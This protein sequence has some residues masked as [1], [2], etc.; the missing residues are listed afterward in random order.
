MIKFVKKW[1]APIPKKM[2]PRVFYM[3]LLIITSAFVE[4]FSIGS[5]FP[6]LIFL[7]GETPE[8]KYFSLL[9]FE[10]IADYLGFVKLISLFII[11]YFLKSIYLIYFNYYKCNLIR[12]LEVHLTNSLFEKY[13][14]LDF[15]TFRKIPSGEIIRNLTKEIS[16]YCSGFASFIY[17]F[18]EAFILIIL[19]GLLLFVDIKATL[20]VLL[21]LSLFGLLLLKV[22]F[23]KLSNLGATRAKAEKNKVQN[24]LGFINLFP[25]TKLYKALPNIKPFFA[26]FTYSASKSQALFNF[27]GQFPRIF[28]ELAAFSVLGILLI[29]SFF[30][31]Y[32]D[33][34]MLILISIFGVVGLRV[35]PSVS[36]LV[37]TAQVV[38][39]NSVSKE[40]IDQIFINIENNAKLERKKKPAFNFKIS[41]DNNLYLEIKNLTYSFVR[42]TKPLFENLSFKA[43][44]GCP[45]CVS[46][47]SGKGKSTLLEVI[48]GLREPNSGDIILYTKKKNAESDFNIGYVGQK[49]FLFPSTIRDNLL[50]GNKNN[51]EDDDIWHSLKICGMYTFVKKIGLSFEVSEDG[52]TFSG[53][54]IQR[55]G[56]ARALLKKPDLLILDEATTGLD[57]KI[58]SDV[59]KKLHKHLS[60]SII[61]HASHS[62]IVK[63]NCKQEFIIK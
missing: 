18:S 23:S 38:R 43:I 63:E 15:S 37:N 35:L 21:V 1:I 5:I 52:N 47:P 14:Q 51:L 57:K 53:G 56:L 24:I 20:S 17:L 59:I 39:F 54:Q 40:I 26:S 42:G 4:L 41:N 46:A 28:M 50:F 36:R 3:F 12:D 58:E 6:L 31:Q 29:I 25:E 34:K 13:H 7:F 61:I 19:L 16:L 48:S 22:T 10:K 49:V 55:L 33:Q 32:S 8:T 2:K 44:S 11:I 62:L 30:Y 9:F 27:I 45:V 60:K